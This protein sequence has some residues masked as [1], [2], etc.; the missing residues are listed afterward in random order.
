MSS[1]TRFVGLDYHQD[2][3]QVCVM[4]QEGQ[5]IANRSVENRW[6]A[7]V[8]VIDETVDAPEGP[9]IVKTSIESCSGAAHLAEELIEQ[10]G[11]AVTLAHPGMV[12][13]MKQNPDK[14]DKADAFIL[15][16]LTLLLGT[17]RTPNF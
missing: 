11:W 7:I 2:S 16:D 15:A 9:V 17:S 12:N 13:R 4:D 6:Q 5:V 10:A 14:S 3:V 1:V 8:D